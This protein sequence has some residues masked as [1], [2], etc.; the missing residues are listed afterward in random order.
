MSAVADTQ[1][2][3]REGAHIGDRGS[4]GQFTGA[5]VE[6]GPTGR[7]LNAESQH[8]AG[9]VGG[10][11]CETVRPVRKHRAARGTADAGRSGHGGWRAAADRRNSR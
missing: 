4:P 9:G 2:N 3:L 11:R 5:A 10:G 7:I 8:I 1:D 6:G